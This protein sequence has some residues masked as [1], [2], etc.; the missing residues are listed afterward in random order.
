MTNRFT[1]NAKLALG[2]YIKIT[3]DNAVE[4]SY[5]QCDIAKE[6]EK[7]AFTSYNDIISNIC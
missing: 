1:E 2:A 6:G 7:Y 5:I 3:R 4:Y